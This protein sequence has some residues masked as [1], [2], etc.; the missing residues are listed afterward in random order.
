MDNNPNRKAP[1]LCAVC[2]HPTIHTTRAARTIVTS[3]TTQTP[4]NLRLRIIASERDTAQGVFG[5]HVAYLGH[6]VLAVEREG[7][8]VVQR[9]VDR[10]GE[11]G[12]RRQRR[13]FCPDRR[14]ELNEQWL[15]L[16][17]PHA[18]TLVWF[19]AADVGFYAV[20]LADHLE[21]LLGIR[22][23]RARVNII[24]VPPCVIPACRFVDLAACV[25]L[26][27]PRVSIGL[28]DAVECNEP[29]LRVDA[30]AIRGEVEPYRSRLSRTRATIVAHVDP[31]AAGHR[32]TV[33]W[34]EHRDRRVV[35]VYLSG[36]QCVALD[37]FNERYTELGNLPEP[38]AHAAA[39]QRHSVAC[40]N[41]RL[42]IQRLM[43]SELRHRNIGQQARMRDAVLDRQARH[44]GLFDVAAIWATQLVADRADH[45]ERGR[46]AGELLGDILAE[47]LHC[48]RAYGASRIRCE[49]DLVARQVRRQWFSRGPRLDGPFDALSRCPRASAA[50]WPAVRSSNCASSLSICR[51]SFSDLLPKYIRLSLSICAFSRS[52]SSSR[53][54]ISCTIF[55][56]DA[57]CSSTRAWSSATV[58]GSGA[59]WDMRRSLRVFFAVYNIDS[60]AVRRGCRQSMPSS[61]IDSWALVRWIFPPSAW[62]QIKRPRSNRF[63][64]NQSPSSVAQSS[65]TRSPRRPRKMN[66]WPPSGF[67][68]SAVCTF[69]ASPWNP[70][71]MSVTPAASQ[72]R[73]PAG[74]AITSDIRAGM[75][76]CARQTSRESSRAACR[77]PPRSRTRV[78]ASVRCSSLPTSLS[79]PAPEVP[80][81]SRSRRRSAVPCMACSAQRRVQGRPACLHDIA[82]AI[83]TPHWR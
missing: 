39:I 26:I 29:G 61:S 59:C 46:H 56:S 52:I 62:G 15:A 45:F 48:S 57:C 79:A 18:Q 32:L 19:L 67:S 22:S 77:S 49:F 25:Q 81:P 10:L 75:L 9:V 83:R 78:S 13:E 2:S 73:V 40:R 55:A 23:R 27:E 65:F 24:D 11:R 74:S 4:H 30:F 3:R 50:P 5:K 28:H 31:E 47:P 36:N 60:A 43:I 21:Q 70:Q 41:L 53:A 72:I 8:P 34:R 17:S 54:A 64:S 69:A 63:A 42:A 66:R 16:L 20:E 7:C 33:A 68:S 58:A 71:R 82:C 76:R 12:L 80:M 51:A 6:T 1:F 14:F 37:R 35:N 44:R 38:A